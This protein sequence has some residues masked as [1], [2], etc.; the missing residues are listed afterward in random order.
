[1][2]RDPLK[3]MRNRQMQRVDHKMRSQSPTNDLNALKTNINKPNPFGSLQNNNKFSPTA[4]SSSSSSIQSPI[5]KLNNNN[6]N[7]NQTLGFRKGPSRLESLP[8]GQSVHLSKSNISLNR[9]QSLAKH[10]NAWGAAGQTKSPVLQRMGSELAMLNKTKSKARLIINQP[11]KG[12]LNQ[13]TNALD[14]RGMLR[15]YG[16]MMDVTKGKSGRRQSLELRTYHGEDERLKAIASY[17]SLT[18]TSSF[19]SARGTSQD[20]ISRLSSQYGNQFRRRR[21]PRKIFVSPATFDK[22][23]NLSKATELSKPQ[24][25]HGLYFIFIC[26]FI[27]LFIYIYTYTN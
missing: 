19:Y 5:N 1:M 21:K 12:K 15:A 18:S 3:V 23:G 8:S 9:I 27:Y 10:A 6:T 16:S 11:N 2:D 25:S 22:K 24:R 17:N 26:L 20:S 13:T 4:S 14:R 7:T